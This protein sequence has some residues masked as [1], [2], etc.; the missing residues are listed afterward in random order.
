MR[1]PK[2][3][4]PP[5]SYRYE[6]IS[7]HIARQ[8][9]SG[10][11]QAGEKIPSTRQLAENHGASINTILHVQKL[12]E[13]QRLIEA[14]P[15]SGYFVT[16]HENA[17][18][19]KVALK[20]STT[21]RLKP[22]LIKHQRVVLDLVQAT[23]SKAVMQLGAALPH[24]EF[25]PGRALQRIATRLARTQDPGFI[26]YE[27][28][29]GLAPLREALAQRMSGF[30]CY[31]DA[32]DILITSGCQ[33]AIAIALKCVTEPGDVVLLESPTYYG[34]LQMVDT[35]GL[36]AIEIPCHP[37]TGVD[38]SKVEDAC[39]QWTVKACVLV[40]NFSNPLGSCPDNTQK[41]ALLSLLN[42][43]NV[44]LVEDDIY[45]DLAFNG[46]RPAPYK[47]FDST[48]EVLYCNSFSKTVSPGLRVGWLAAGRYAEKAAYLKFTQNIASPSLNQQV[49]N[50]Y[51]LTGGVDKHLRKLRAVYAANVKRCIDVIAASFP[52]DTRT[53]HPS[54][55]FVV[56]V[57]LANKVDTA[58]LYHAAL[59]HKI[60][61]APGYLFSSDR[62]FKNYFR[63][64]CALPW[65][66][67]LAPAL[68]I[69]SKLLND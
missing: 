39:R 48:G 42:R 59:Q 41:K 32:A 1:Q 45:G 69:L 9:R 18:T 47:Q 6:Q 35:L 51:L 12:L 10:H 29:P 5:S 17:S 49:L 63:I 28:P 31:V 57:E 40:S 52:E 38:L 23:S 54:G 20:N 24:E 33:E 8:I 53:S 64:N 68:Q 46:R 34:L 16:R 4:A 15:R 60:S 25:F 56:W 61:I 26:R 19:E 65:E 21:R 66:S 22:S 43:F 37:D 2:P 67:I 62:R 58:E 3:P 44:P 36:R 55:G 30:G 7:A 13:N 11:Y 50:E 14:K 27:V